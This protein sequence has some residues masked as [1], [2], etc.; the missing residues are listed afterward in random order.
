MGTPEFAVPPLL[1]IIKHHQVV[2][3]LTQPD[4]PA[5]RGHKLT[6]SPVKVA[7]LAHGIEV[8]Q[9]ETLRIRKGDNEAANAAAKEAR[10]ILQ[11]YGADIFVVAAYGLILPKAVLE[12][13]RRG[14][15]NIHASLLPKYRGASPI[16][17]AL[18]NGDTETGITIIHM[19][20]GI[21]TGDMILKRSLVIPQEEHFP[22][23]HNRMAALGAATIIEALTALDNGSAERT[24][25]NHDIHSY[26]PMIKK[27]DGQINWQTT[28]QEII[29]KT[30]ALDPWPGAYTSLNG[31]PLKIWQAE[32]TS[33]SQNATNSISPG[34][35]LTANPTDGL[36]IK[37]ADG[38]IKITE[39]QPPDKKR[40]PTTD[41]LRGQKLELGLI[42][43]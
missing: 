8:L 20:T 17:A 27:T 3:V 28:S 16:H 5:G 26:A 42:L 29:N 36:T 33:W 4:R 37:T 24:P 2:A 1:E 35:V 30:R 32:K 6:P 39:I 12:M 10:S 25:Q 15:I 18:L 22:S 31:Q 40:M 11:G 14:S 38:A 9:P 41:Y 34:A 43:G 19:D 21:D 7:A 23:L 13:P